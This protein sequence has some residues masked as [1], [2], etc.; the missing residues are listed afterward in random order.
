MSNTAPKYNT[1]LITLG[2]IAGAAVGTAWVSTKKRQYAREGTPHLMEWNRVRQ[3]AH[4]II[5]EE[6]PAPGWHESWESYYRDMVARCYPVITAEIGRELPVPLDSIQAFSR[7]EW[8]DANIANFR[9]LFEPIEAMYMRAQGPGN[10][11]TMLM[12]DVSQSVLS[13]Q[14]GI[15]LGYLAR[16]VLGQYDLSLLGKEPVS[17]GRLY[18]VEPNINAVQKELGLDADDFRLWIALHETTHAYEFEAYPW[19]REYFNSLL[20]EYFSLISDDILQFGSN[21]SGVRGLAERAMSNISSGENWIEKMMSPEQRVL[22]NKLQAL[23]SI[24]EGYSN[25]IMNAVG[26]RLLPSYN[27]IKERFEARAANRSSAEKLFVRITGLA[28]KMEQYRLGEAF[29]N[30]VVA[31]QGVSLANR[32][33]EGPD[34][35]P[36]MEELRNPSMW[37]G[38]I[39]REA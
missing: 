36:T 19:V 34:F 15:L 18:F 14:L 13:G 31:Q 24:I 35:M 32:V 9:Q 4:Q 6:A 17:Q 38:R 28:L 21:L 3:M 23:M 1:R 37:V 30:A 5:R 10:L 12:G 26:E 2:L 16:R 29:I 25:Y 8:I 22:F 7:N 39:Q 11:G 20:E 27:V 33:W